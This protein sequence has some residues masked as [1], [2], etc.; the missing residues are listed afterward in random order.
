[1]PGGLEARLQKALDQRK[2]DNA[3][4][5][6]PSPSQTVDLLSNDYLGLARGGHLLPKDTASMPP[7]G[8]TGSR[9]LSGNT[10]FHENLE[11]E[12][13]NFHETSSA[14][15]FNTGY[16]A[17]LTL[18]SS[19]MTKDD[20]ILYDSYL[21]AS[22]RQGLQLSH[23]RCYK[24]RHND[25]N[26]LLHK[27]K[28]AKGQVLVVVESIYSMD[29]DEAPLHSL[30]ECCHEYGCDLVVD[31]AH[32]TGI[33]GNCGEGLVQAKGLSQD[34]FARIHTFGKAVGTQGAVV[35]GSPVLKAYLVNFGKP[36]IYTT[37]PPPLLLQCIRNS[38]RTF[39]HMTDARQH[40]KSLATYLEG[41]LGA[42]GYDVIEGPGPIK[43]L[44]MPGNER[45][46]QAS[47]KLRKAGFEVRPI[48]AP[49]VPLGQE[50][51]RFCLHAYNTFAE[52]D[53]L[54]KTLTSMD[55]KEVITNA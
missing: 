30:V 49:T 33:M 53:E 6:L 20:T 41:L 28:S 10:P 14:I 46:K 12:L 4:R 19:L 34:V 31:E 37:A 16:Q 45:V 27:I 13:A 47:Q 17:N 1:M 38:Y 26:S 32:A 9:L 35:V 24:F 36:F 25:V 43:A 51:I 3:Y 52:L 11:A 22:L 44:I 48:L 2:A 7:A 42:H 55:Q 39:P 29:G 23:A 21:H 18:L 8:A 54:A 5:S 15:L 40:V 50:R